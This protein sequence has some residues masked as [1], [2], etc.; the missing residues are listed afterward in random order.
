MNEGNAS[1]RK[2][3]EKS[4]SRRIKAKSLILQETFLCDARKENGKIGSCRIKAKSLILQE[5]FRFEPP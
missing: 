3:T 5:I 4:G 2:K 1:Q